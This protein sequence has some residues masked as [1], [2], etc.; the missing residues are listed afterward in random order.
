ML[1][2]K[3]RIKVWIERNGQHLF[4]RGRAELLETI[5]REGS[6]QA[7]ARKMGVSYRRAWTMLRT[8]ERRLGGKLLESTRGGAGGGRTRLTE[9][10]RGFLDVFRRIEFR[11]QQVLEEQQN[12]L[13]RLGR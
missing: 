13:D 11:F 9:A 3:L 5:A 10:G 1:Q 2:V 7:A 8:S 4:G 6:I 12:E